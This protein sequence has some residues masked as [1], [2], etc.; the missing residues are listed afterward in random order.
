MIKTIVVATD[1]S[2]TATRAVKLSAEMAQ[3][4]NA[5][6]EIVSVIK[7][8]TLSN[9]DA[10]YSFYDSM[11]SELTKLADEYI[12]D[13]SKIMQEANIEFGTHTFNGDPRFIL[14]EDVQRELHPDI[15]IMG[16]TGTSVVS[17][18][19]VGSTARYVSEHAEANV[20]LVN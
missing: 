17:R 8:P 18:L 9:Y 1:G 6:V 16:K 13:A 4:Y 12:A 15:I 10:S 11:Q 5:K 14:V 20:L 2:D 19:F 7:Y 3:K